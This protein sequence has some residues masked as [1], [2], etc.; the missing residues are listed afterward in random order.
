MEYRYK[1]NKNTLHVT[2]FI[3]FELC[4]VKKKLIYYLPTR[5]ATAE[6]YQSLYDDSVTNRY[7]IQIKAE[8][9]TNQYFQKINA[10]SA[11]LKNNVIFKI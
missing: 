9:K 4:N 3:F 5:C 1:F 6:V 11:F 2:K 7:E 8:Q 10:C